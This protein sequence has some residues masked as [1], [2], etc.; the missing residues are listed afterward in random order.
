ML[1]RVLWNLIV[2]LMGEGRKMP[3]NPT[4]RRWTI[5]AWLKVKKGSHRAV[6]TWS[7]GICLAKCKVL[8]SIPRTLKKKTKQTI[9]R[10]CSCLPS[11]TWV[12]FH[13]IV[14]MMFINSGQ[15]RSLF[16]SKGS[17]ISFKVKSK[18]PI[19]ES[20]GPSY[21]SNLMPS[22][23]SLLTVLTP[24]CSPSCSQRATY[25]QGLCPRRPLFLSSFCISGST[26]PSSL[27]SGLCS[28]LR[29]SLPGFLSSPSP[30]LTLLHSSTTRH[31]IYLVW[32]VL[33]LK[34]RQQELLSTQ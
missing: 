6:V 1:P 26:Q 34:G 13:T 5:S 31:Y 7:L 21:F 14:R 20:K 9:P 29:S 10:A 15:I 24:H 2:I 8:G 4:E 12:D 3:A 27:P 25:T 32:S 33:L 19:I 18:S 30:V 16:Y 11:P 22:L 28:S 17:P 23:L